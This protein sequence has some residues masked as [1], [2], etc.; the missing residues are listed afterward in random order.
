MIYIY[1]ITMM[2]VMCKCVSIVIFLSLRFGDVTV[3]GLVQ[4]TAGSTE[5]TEQSH[6]E[7][8]QDRAQLISFKT[9]RDVCVCVCV[10]MFLCV[11]MHETASLPCRHLELWQDTILTLLLC[12][13]TRR[14]ASPQVQGSFS[15]GPPFYPQII[16]SSVPAHSRQSNPFMVAQVGAT[17]QR[18]SPVVYRQCISRIHSLQ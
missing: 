16:Q 18:I 2:L 8:R 7:R 10:L 14:I 6:Q 15:T 1:I 5:P 3:R 13:T 17:S 11:C 9:V 12:R 4:F